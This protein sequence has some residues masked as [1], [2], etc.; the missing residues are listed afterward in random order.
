MKLKIIIYSI[1]IAIVI[2]LITFFSLIDGGY[3]N[4]I[5]IKLSNQNIKHCVLYS[6]NWADKTFYLIYYPMNK[7][8]FK[9][10]LW[11]NNQDD[12]EYID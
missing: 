7:I 3:R 11:V 2:Y 4:R 6:D 12:S 10:I 8:F 9:S 1:A 5:S